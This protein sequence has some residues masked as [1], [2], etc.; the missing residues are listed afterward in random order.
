MPSSPQLLCF[1]QQYRFISKPVR[2]G[3]L[4]L[5]SSHGLHPPYI[6]FWATP[7]A[8]SWYKAVYRTGLAFINNVLFFGQQFIDTVSQVGGAFGQVDELARLPVGYSWM[9][10]SL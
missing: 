4:A 9:A 5:D 1:P 2:S 3:D 8:A 6:S 10:F 7:P